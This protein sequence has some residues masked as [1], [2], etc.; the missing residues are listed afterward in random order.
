MF[1]K[2]S[3]ALCSLIVA[4]GCT[5]AVSAAEAVDFGG[6][7][8]DNITTFGDMNLDGKVTAEDATVMLIY[9]AEN[10]IADDEISVD[11]FLAAYEIADETSEY[12]SA[13]GDVNADGT[14][15]PEDATSV[16]LFYADAL[17]NETSTDATPWITDEES[18][19]EESSEDT[20][21]E[22]SSEVSTEAEPAAL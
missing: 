21:E 13:L 6:A 17:L 7:E 8:K 20:S 5:A 14:V 12:P 15:S 22:A 11:D 3:A 18:S 9:S 2:I 19:S 1:K 16:L 4:A 10:L